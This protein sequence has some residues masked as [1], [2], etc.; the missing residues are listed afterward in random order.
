MEHYL[1]FGY[2][3]THIFPF[4]HICWLYAC[5]NELEHPEPHMVQHPTPRVVTGPRE[6][7]QRRTHLPEDPH[8][9]LPEDTD[10][11]SFGEMVL[12]NTRM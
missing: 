7:E 8:I 12:S 10:A 2:N 11:E 6:Q 4:I 1:I 5:P 9:L 3:L